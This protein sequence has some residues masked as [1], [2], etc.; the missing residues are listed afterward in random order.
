MCGASPAAGCAGRAR[1]HLTRARA[2]RTSKDIR[3]RDVGE[4]GAGQHACA[5]VRSQKSSHK[6]AARA[7]KVNKSNFGE[8]I[9]CARGELM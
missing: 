2:R 4:Q 8:L 6:F 9:I 3:A 7:N 5:R 1:E